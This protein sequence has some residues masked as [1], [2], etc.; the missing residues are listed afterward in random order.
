M[1]TLLLATGTEHMGFKSVMKNLVGFC[2]FLVLILTLKSEIF[3]RQMILFIVF[4]DF[5]VFYNFSMHHK[6]KEKKSID[7]KGKSLHIID[8]ENS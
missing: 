7:S 2:E 3:L 8:L 4:C 5:T 1:V 6:F